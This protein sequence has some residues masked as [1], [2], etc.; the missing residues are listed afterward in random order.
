MGKASKKRRIAA[1]EA[2]D[3]ERKRARRPVIEETA[4]MLIDFQ[5]NKSSQKLSHEETYGGFGAVLKEKQRIYPWLTMSM[6]T[7]KKTRIL[8]QEEKKAAATMQQQEQHAKEGGSKK[9][10]T[11]EEANKDVAQKK[12]EAKVMLTERYAK[13]KAASAKRLPK[14]TYQKLHDGLL[15]ELG[16]R[17]IGFSIPKT[18]IED[19]VR[20]KTTATNPGPVSPAAAIEPYILTILHYSKEAGKSLTEQEIIAFANS[21]IEGSK[22]EDSLKAFHARN[23]VQPRQLLGKRWYNGFMKRNKEIL[24]S[25]KISSSITGPIIAYIMANAAT[26][27]AGAANARSVVTNSEVEEK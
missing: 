14:G 15:E 21:S 22:V 7:G 19:R 16:L 18:T 12:A 2:P 20:N 13:A 4:R 3:I 6:V 10:S 1:P 5:A 25:G 27:E 9:G 26:I 8:K 11:E 17:G 23:G 24:N